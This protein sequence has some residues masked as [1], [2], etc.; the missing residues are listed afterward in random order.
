[1]RRPWRRHAETPAQ[2]LAIVAAARP[3]T[4]ILDVEPFVVRWEQDDD[5]WQR[6]AAEVADAIAGIGGVEALV[7]ASNS[8]RALALPDRATGPAV[9]AVPG[10]GKPWRRRAYRDLPRPLVVIGDQVLTDGLLAWLL[11]APFVQYRPAGRRPWWPSIQH[12]LGVP[13][14]VL[15]FRRVPH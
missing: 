15:A 7:Y 3:R 1:M 5:A 12:V 4:L 8:T 13:V 9:R 14:G 11:S 6:R 2:V 10:A